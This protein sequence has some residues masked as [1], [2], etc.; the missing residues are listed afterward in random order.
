M[1]GLISVLSFPRRQR[2]HTIR[3]LALPIVAGMVSQNLLNLVDA[4]MVGVLGE[5]ALA[6][7]GI[8]SFASLML[9]T[10]I[11]GVASGG[12]QAMSARRV[13]EGRE[14]EAALVL[15]GGLAFA[16]M[17]GVPVAV[18]LVVV[19]PRVFVWLNSDPEVLHQGVPYMQARLVAIAAIAMNFAFRGYWNGVRR[20]ELYMRVLIVMHLANVV[21]DW[22]LIFGKFGAPPLGTFGA[23]LASTIA[24]VIGTLY[25]FFL[26]WR[27]ARSRGFL[28]RLPD[29]RTLATMLRLGIPSGLQ[30]FSFFFGLTALFWIVGRVGTTELAAATALMNITL[31]AILPGIGLGLA[32]ATL[33]GQALGR[34]E[35]ADAMRWGWDVAKLGAACTLLVALPMVAVPEWIMSGFLHE[36]GALELACWPLRMVGLSLSLD[37]AGIVLS[38]ALLGAGDNR[39]VFL[40]SVVAQ[41]CLALPAAWMAGMVWGLGLLGIWVTVTVWRASQAAVYGYFWYA[42]AWRSLSV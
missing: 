40:V 17:V 23:G 19:T 14:D 24:T 11:V 29:G 5:S 18:L 13:G 37:I 35:P 39:R 3:L 26:A 33:V 8:G 28:S 38:N 21:L 12:V 9:S 31:V 20:S 25:Y 36:P 4:A 42:G 10:F 15:N 2:L 22:I 6:A 34:S 32:A 1:T 16:V 27:H 7:V 30:Q 41:W